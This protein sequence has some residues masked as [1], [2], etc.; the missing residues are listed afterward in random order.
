[1]RVALHL[2]V[3]ER[4]GCVGLFQHAPALQPVGGTLQLVRRNRRRVG[5]DKAAKVAQKAYQEGMALLEACVAL[6]YLSGEEYDRLLRPEEM[7]RPG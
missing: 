3:D 1:M 6:G 4:S 2:I 5:Y 7:T